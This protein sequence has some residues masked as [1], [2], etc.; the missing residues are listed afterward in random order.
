MQKIHETQWEQIAPAA[1]DVFTDSAVIPL[2]VGQITVPSHVNVLRS[3]SFS[4]KAKQIRMFTDIF[5]IDSCRYLYGMLPTIDMLVNRI[6]DES[7]QMCYRIVLD[8]IEKNFKG[9]IPGLFFGCSLI[10]SNIN[11][12][13]ERRFSDREFI[14]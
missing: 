8:D 2:L 13:E 1:C 10:G 5:V 11:G 3:Q 9:Y 14:N 4:Y 7:S 12:F 6:K